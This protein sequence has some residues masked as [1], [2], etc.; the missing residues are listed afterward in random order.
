M[1][2]SR[3]PSQ[4]ARQTKSLGAVR[5]LSL[6]IAHI[7]R[8]A[9]VPLE[10]ADRLNLTYVEPVVVREPSDCGALA[11]A[12]RF[13]VERQVAKQIFGCQRF[14]KILGG[15]RDLTPGGKHLSK[16]RRAHGSAVGKALLDIRPQQG[17]LRPVQQVSLLLPAEMAHD[18]ADR[19]HLAAVLARVVLRH[20][21]EAA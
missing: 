10:L 18:P 15:G 11:L 20:T 7:H 1:G 17:P 21:F 19:V 14:E 9:L 4:G 13:A 16:G 8:K 6:D 5:S 12:R 3:L 2:S